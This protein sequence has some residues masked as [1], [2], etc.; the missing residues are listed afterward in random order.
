MTWRQ[1]MALRL[2]FQWWAPLRLN[3]HS[4]LYSSH[5]QFGEAL[6]VRPLLDEGSP[7]FYV[8]AGAR[9]PVYCS[10]TCHFYRRGWRGINIEAFP[11]ALESFQVLRPRDIN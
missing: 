1:T 4:S 9:H 11:G 7:G 5:S 8:E 3:R 2:R 6:V 10:N